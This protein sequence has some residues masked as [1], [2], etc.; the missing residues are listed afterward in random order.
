[1]C[2]GGRPRWTLGPYMCAESGPSE[3]WGPHKCANPSWTERGKGKPGC[4]FPT[5][6]ETVCSKVIFFL[7]P[8]RNVN[9]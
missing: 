6:G 9:M 5:N 1:M 3:P 8:K 4:E 2:R 7:K